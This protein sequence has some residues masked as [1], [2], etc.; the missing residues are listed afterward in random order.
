MA[1]EKAKQ[2]S[3]GL[4]KLTEAQKEAIKALYDAKDKRFAEV[5]KLVNKSELY[6]I[7]GDEKFAPKVNRNEKAE[8]LNSILFS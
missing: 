4:K 8:L 3:S 7:T 5:E 2:A 6:K 1:N